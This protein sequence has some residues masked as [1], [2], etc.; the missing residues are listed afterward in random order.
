MVYRTSKLTKFKRQAVRRRRYA[1]RVRRPA[2]RTVFNR[3]SRPLTGMN[4]GA[5]PLV[6][7]CKLVYSTYVTLST[8]VFTG[9]RFRLSSLFDPE[10]VAV[11]HQPRGFDELAAIYNKYRVMGT[12]VKIQPTITAGPGNT[13]FICLQAYPWSTGNVTSFNEAKEAIN[14]S[15]ILASSDRPMTIKKYFPTYKSLGVTKRDFMSDESYAAVVTTN[16]SNSAMLH[17]G[18][19]SPDQS[20]LTTVTCNVTFV[21]YCQFSERRI[22][23]QS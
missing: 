14:S 18:V 23:P 19:A 22:L 3:F 1:L 6:R 13:A 15:A 9:T 4:N 12:A 2:R 10:F 21:F 8:S 17:L 5:F 20:T 7:N 16:P 11:G